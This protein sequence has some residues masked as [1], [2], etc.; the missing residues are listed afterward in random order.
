MSKRAS[1]RLSL[2]CVS[3]KS[4]K[5]WASGVT[6][7]N[8][9]VEVADVKRVVFD[10]LKARGHMVGHAGCEHRVCRRRIHQVDLEHFAALRIHRGFPQLL[11][12]HFAQAFKAL[13]RQTA[14]TDLL[15]LLQDLGDG[16]YRCP[17]FDR[18]CLRL[19]FFG[20]SEE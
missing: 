18:L 7:C 4:I 11:G 14:L 16:V 6:A 9:D 19:W 5:S 12:I 3:R 1:L 8:L 17:L 10:E 2:A 13:D 15:D 20:R